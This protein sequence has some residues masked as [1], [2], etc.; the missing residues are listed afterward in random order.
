MYKVLAWAHNIQVKVSNK[1]WELTTMK[2]YKSSFNTCG[3]N[4][5]IAKGVIIEGLENIEVGKNVYIGPGA[6][7]YSTDA[8]LSIGDDFIGGP[9]L[10]IMTGDHRFDITGKTISNTIE[11]KASDDQNVVIEEDV[12][13]GANVLI[14]KGVTIGKG[15]VIGAGATVVKNVPPY[16]IY[17][18]KNLI[19]KRFT[20]EQITEHEE[21]LRAKGGEKY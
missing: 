20:D 15:S 13:I 12:W 10:T 3:D 7:I 5:R 16:S 11:K 21:K 4:L 19:K 2:F 18:S 8:S 17:I 9:R 14:L 1:W 6:I